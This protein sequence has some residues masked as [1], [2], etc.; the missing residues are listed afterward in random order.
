MEALLL[1]M[2][3]SVLWCFCGRKNYI[4]EEVA[5]GSGLP[6]SPEDQCH[7]ISK[8]WVAIDEMRSYEKPMRTC[9]EG[10]HP[11]DGFY[12]VAIIASLNSW[13]GKV[14]SSHAT[15]LSEI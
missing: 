9:E 8:L 11:I 14:L 2:T 15:L 3:S 10:N 12:L 6:I 13:Q 7:V 4:T 5:G 1:A